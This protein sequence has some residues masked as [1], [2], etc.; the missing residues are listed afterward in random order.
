M[1]KEITKEMFNG[2]MNGEIEP[3]SVYST[4]LIPTATKNSQDMRPN[5]QLANSNF[6]FIYKYL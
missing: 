5:T 2:M 3:N 6:N 4:I 1:L